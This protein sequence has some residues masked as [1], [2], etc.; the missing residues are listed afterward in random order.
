M[1][2]KDDGDIPHAEGGGVETQE[3]GVSVDIFGLFGG[4]PTPAPQESSG[5][6]QGIQDEIDDEPASEPRVSE[7]E[8]AEPPEPPQ[9]E[10][11]GG[12]EE[13]EEEEFVSAT[14]GAPG[15]G[16]EEKKEV[17][18]EDQEEKGSKAEV[19]ETPEQIAESIMEM[20]IKSTE[21]LA[22]SVS[23]DSL[24][25]SELKETEEQAAKLAQLLAERKEE[26]LKLKE[27][28]PLTVSDVDQIKEKQFEIKEMI[29]E[30]EEL[31]AKMKELLEKS[32]RPSG[33]VK[34]GVE[35]CPK[36]GKEECVCQL[37]G[38][39]NL[40]PVICT[41]EDEVCTCDKPKSYIPGGWYDLQVPDLFP[42]TPEVREDK[43]CVCKKEDLRQFNII[44]D[45]MPKVVV[46]APDVSLP[47]IIVCEPY[48]PL[49][50]KPRKPHV[51]APNRA[52]KL[53]RY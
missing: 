24:V 20:I 11:G 29:A 53:D 30:F 4:P 26:I 42:H 51:C 25:L 31:T 23:L 2:G 52:C 5:G 38:D 50:Q 48:T 49:K 34:P 22:H 43:E 8:G 33:A 19:E 35:P 16:K 9:E 37:P 27:K 46:C 10:G 41:C 28:G 18:D 36:C 13:E 1:A 44:A 45:I 47:R 32:L 39:E 14:E 6:A 40:P 15:E 3:S 12:D 7:S 21:Q 17:E